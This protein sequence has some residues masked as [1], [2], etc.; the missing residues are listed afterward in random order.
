MGKKLEAEK[1]GAKAKDIAT[2]ADIDIDQL[3]G[4]AVCE[5]VAVGDI[6]VSSK[7]DVPNA[8]SK[9]ATSEEGKVDTFEVSCWD[10]KTDAWAKSMAKETGDTYTCDGGKSKSYVGSDIQVKQA[11]AAPV[12]TTVAAAR[13]LTTCH[14]DASIAAPSAVQQKTLTY[15]DSARNFGGLDIKKLTDAEQE[16]FDPKAWS[17]FPCDL[18][19]EVATMMVS[20]SLAALTAK[21]VVDTYTFA[22]RRRPSQKSSVASWSTTSARAAS[23]HKYHAAAGFFK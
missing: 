7:G 10:K 2:E 3:D 17:F 5:H 13:K 19:K 23:A 21:A 16:L 8:K 18:T 20:K 4:A 9:M 22:R 12:S 6:C 14:F 15:K 1:K 11:T